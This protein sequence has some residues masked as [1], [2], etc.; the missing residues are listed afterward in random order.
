MKTKKM[1]LAAI[2]CLASTGGTLAQDYANQPLCDRVK[3]GGYGLLGYDYNHKPEGQDVSTFRLRKFEILGRAQITDK[4]SFNLT[5]EAA[6]YSSTILKDLNMTYALS[7]AFKVRVGQFKTPFSIENNIAPFFNDLIT[8]GS[9]PTVYFNGIGGDP[10]SV[11]NAGRDTGVEIAG[12]LFNNLVSYRLM[13]ANGFGMNRTNNKRAMPLYGSLCLHPF[14]GVDLYG[15]AVVGKF[16]AQE[17]AKG[18]KAGDTYDRTRL[19]IGSKIV[20]GPFQI[21]GEYFYGKDNEVKG[22]GAYATAHLTV[23]KGLDLIAAGDWLKKDNESE[24]SDTSCYAGA[25]YWFY[26]NCRMQMAYQYKKYG[27]SKLL[28]E[29]IL[30][31]QLQFVF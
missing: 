3:I 25:Q 14:A 9:A 28:D 26:K 7:P 13:L 17:D 19:S 23:A 31:T 22:Q 15:S 20:Q 11:R 5:F 4:W 30:W 12:D 27:E 21:V 8:T 6:N 10:L 29:H 16:T 1:L 18:I 2:L 24:G